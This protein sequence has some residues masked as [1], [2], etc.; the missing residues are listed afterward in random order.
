MLRLHGYFSDGAIVQRGAPITVKGCADAD[1]VCTLKGKKSE[2]ILKVSPQNGAFCAVFSAVNDVENEYVL[3]AECGAERASAKIR[4]GDVYLA[5][6]QSN[7]SYALSAAEDAEEW[8]RRAKNA[9]VSVLD[10]RERP[11]EDP[12]F[13]ERPAYPLS[14]FI[15]PYAWRRGGDLQDVSALSVMTAVLSYENG[16]VPIG[17]VHTSMGG[18]SVE[19]YIRRETAESDEALIEYLKKCGRYCSVAEYNRSGG[20]NFTQLSGV[21]NEKI[22][23][24]LGFSFSGIVWYLGESS[25]NDYE[26]ARAY[27]TLMRMLLRDYR[28]AFGE[29][30]FVAVQI[31]PEYYPYGDRYGYLYVN[32]VI[33]DLESEKN[34]YAVPIYDIEPRWLKPNGELYFHP[35]HP[36]NKSPVAHRIFECLNGRLRRYPRIESTEICGG[37]MI[38][39]IANGVL[40]EGTVQG[41]TVA[42]KNGKYYPAIAESFG[43]FVCV[44]SPD[45]SQPASVTYAF[46]QYQDFCDAKTRE[47]AP[48]LP[49][50]SE[51]G[52]VSGKYC[53]T[54]PFCLRGVRK[55]YENCFGWN[56][57]TCRK[58]D[59]WKKG[60]I[61]DASPTEFVNSADAVFRMRAFP[62]KTEYGLF[63]VSPAVCLSGHHNHISDFAF[64]NVK[65]SCR[66]GAEFLGVVARAADGEV[67]RASL[68]AA[69]GK[70]ESALLDETARA[71][72]IGWETGQR[73]DYCE[74]SFSEKLRK[75]FVQVEFLFRASEEAE[76][77]LH[78]LELSDSERSDESSEETK[79]A[80]S[81]ADIV[82]P[83]SG[84]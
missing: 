8:L 19:A 23:P 44:S 13:A 12:A 17:F 27:D 75:S 15:Q 37:K 69:G 60:E 39:R 81:R 16:G 40:R 28:A 49:Y 18:L 76:V 55:T 11:C 43:D 79:R 25:A 3:S 29:I 84:C 42:A 47:G 64:W 45:V 6:G 9:D 80:E 70:R 72:A 36:V 2:Q 65:L 22:A 32:E 56:V 62:Q 46:M 35:I 52:A 51:R 30:P 58:T 61:Y 68:Y 53:F 20:R 82:L 7:M 34:V 1:I 63:G 50:R 4:F 38:C 83:S 57:G 78:S 33:S 5:A 67:Y 26:S 41:F 10:L 71:F 59:V 14:D 73:G 54:P 48:L 24:L 74:I 31:A 77:T 66:G 21:W